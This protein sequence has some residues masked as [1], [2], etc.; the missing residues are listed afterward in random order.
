[1]RDNKLK[2][3]NDQRSP[4][5]AMMGSW[6]FS[7]RDSQPFGKQLADKPTRSHTEVVWTISRLQITWYLPGMTAHVRHIV[8]TCEI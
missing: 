2:R 1:M 3:I 4:I 6:G 7:K 5:L 8:R